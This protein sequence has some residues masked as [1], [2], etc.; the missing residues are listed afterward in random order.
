MIR[1]FR[2]DLALGIS[3]C[4]VFLGGLQTLLEGL[5]LLDEEPLIELLQP[6]LEHVLVRDQAKD[7]E[8]L[9]LIIAQP[10][11]NYCLTNPMLCSA[12]TLGMTINAP[13]PAYSRTISIHC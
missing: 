1:G 8:A 10:S 3:D 11:S 12:T 5:L 2:L 13:I 4:V 7:P 9:V 6:A